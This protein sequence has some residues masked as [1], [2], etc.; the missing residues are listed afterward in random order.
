MC[1]PCWA[2][3]FLRKHL[4]CEVPVKSE[5]LSPACTSWDTCSGDF[6]WSH[7]PF[8]PGP[9]DLATT[10]WSDWRAALRV[11]CESSSFAKMHGTSWWRW[12]DSWQSSLTNFHQIKVASRPHAAYRANSLSYQQLPVPN[13]PGSSFCQSFV[14]CSS[15]L[16]LS[17]DNSSVEI[18]VFF[19]FT[20][21]SSCQLTLSFRVSKGM[22]GMYHLMD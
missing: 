5:G 10:W 4:H 20:W 13:G 3:I 11:L 6:S 15:Q 8:L 2:P 16:V 17:S 18:P 12:W 9:C 1:R 14:L 7:Q 22:S 21:I 19:F